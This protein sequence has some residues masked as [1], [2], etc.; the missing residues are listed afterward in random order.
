LRFTP[1]G[2][3]LAASAEPPGLPIVHYGR[4]DGDNRI[5]DASGDVGEGEIGP[6]VHGEGRGS[7]RQ[8]C[9][10]QHAGADKEPE[11][12]VDRHLGLS[13]K[14]MKQNAKTPR[15]TPPFI[16]WGINVLN[17]IFPIRLRISDKG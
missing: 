11:P 7:A 1:L 8:A 2:A 14:N 4:R 3:A 9:N 16:R 5:F 13:L 17:A 10:S 12:L 6:R 15:K